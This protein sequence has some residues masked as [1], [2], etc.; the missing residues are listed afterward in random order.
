MD[1]TLS[2]S[3][4]GDYVHYLAIDPATTR[5]EVLR[6]WAAAAAYGREHGVFRVLLD[7]SDSSIPSNVDWFSAVLAFP[8]WRSSQK[9][10][11]A[12]LYSF[13]TS[14]YTRS[15]LEGFAEFLKAIRQEGESFW[16]RESAET[17]LSREA[18]R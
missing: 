6:R 5:E 15:I 17:W 12:L 3:P 7:F 10:R 1:F 4:S 18:R 9:W 13:K 8:D 16:D 2:M 11:I 14:S